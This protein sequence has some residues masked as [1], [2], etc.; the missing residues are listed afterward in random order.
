[1]SNGIEVK[2]YNISGLNTL[3]VYEEASLKKEIIDLE[4]KARKQAGN[5][6][7]KRIREHMERHNI[8]DYEK[9]MKAVLNTDPELKQQYAK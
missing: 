5:L 8:E 3:N 7:D 4:V 9:A 1:M 2:K 6:V